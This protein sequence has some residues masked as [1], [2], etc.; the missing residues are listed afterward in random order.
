MLHSSPVPSG[1]PGLFTDLYELTMAASYHAR[2]LDEPATFDLF[3]RSLPEQRRFL[4][5][6][7]LE[8]SLDYLESLRFGERELSYLSSL[9]LFEASFLDRLAELR[10]SGEVWAVPE[11]QAVFEREPVMRVTAPLIEAQLVETYLL[12]CL[13]HQTMVA[14]KAARVALACGDHDFV[15]FSARRVQGSDAALLG[16]RASHVAGASAT[17]L[18]LA[19]QVFGIP[20]SGTMAHSYVMRFEREADAFWA[21]ARDLPGRAVLLIDTYDT[22]EG[23]RRAVE[24]AREL[25]EDGVRLQAVRLD[26]G[27]LGALS[28]Q[29]RSVLDEGGFGDVRIV[30]S[31]DL[32][33]YRIASLL[34]QAAPI[35]SF[36]V[37]TRMGASTDAP[38]LNAVYKLVEDADGPKLK[39]SPDKVTLPG[40]KQVHRTRGAA[41]I[42]SDVVAL[43]DEEVSGAE[44][45]LERV[46]ADGERTSPSPSLDAIRRR[47]E[48][49][50]ALLPQRLRGLD[51]E[52]F[53][54]FPVTVS[55]GLQDLLTRIGQVHE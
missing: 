16:S 17:S 15:D 46:L 33:E 39:L 1:G 25:A 5:S 47:C 49:T 12:N 24:V 35:D 7:G 42:E 4:V 48:E 2:G 37:G 45:L 51:L 13:S 34:D 28:R 30:A 26:S 27:D 54:P 21:F 55:V 19:G 3:F 10:F 41:G 8:Q 38:S 22:V 44:P 18:V 29:V 36:G 50:L 20:V 11:G 53:E 23:A 9:D 31:G 40:R 6:C 32:D 43:H 52:E 14:S